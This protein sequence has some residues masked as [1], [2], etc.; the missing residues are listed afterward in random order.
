V[1]DLPFIVALASALVFP[2]GTYCADETAIPTSLSSELLARSACSACHLFP[3]PRLLDKT[4]WT[5][6][7][8]PKM[9][10]YM[11]LDKIDLAASKD[12]EALLK[13]GFLPAAPLIPESS[14][15][16]ITNWYLARAPEPTNTPSRNGFIP[17]GMQ[18]F[19]V[20]APPR[21]RTPPLTTFVQIDPKD[22]VVFAADANEQAL[23]VLGAAGEQIAAPKVGNIITSMQ[24]SKEGF[25]LGCIGHF[26]PT[27]DKLGQV[28][29]LKETGKGLERKVLFSELPRVAHIEAGDFNGDQREDFALS[30]FGFHTGRFSWFENLGE[31]KYQEHVILNKA[32]AVKSIAHDFN[33][34][35]HADLAVLYGQ[36][37]DSLFLF[38][39]DGKGE[40][41]QKDVFRRAPVY[42]H[43][44]F[45]L[46]DFNGDGEIDFLVANGDNGYYESPPKPYHGVRIYTKNGGG[47]EE[48]YFFPQHGAFKAMARD[49]D[50]DGD[51][52]IASI[53][54]FP[55][56]KE[57]PRESFVM[58][59][60]K[61]GL[62]FE[63]S[64]FRECIA[65]RWVTMDANDLDGDG[66]IDIVLA[67]LIRMPTIVPDFLK[68]LWEKQS[69]SVLYLINQTRDR[70][71]K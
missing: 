53:S 52:D 61:G 65:G 40:F 34:D 16:R 39:N 15:E 35:G 11:G 33:K 56:Y 3:D 17:L 2:P 48:A 60:N 62:K 13:A 55:D 36:E 12:G 14:W 30:M 66:D 8:F 54:F 69:P 20:V 63:P 6:H 57:S 38:I 27:E 51:L 1:R 44:Y 18:N 19:K 68:E 45:E 47:Y 24:K 23:E 31:D 9:R 70:A 71:R 4:I 43:A 42:G 58:L 22:H 49:F 5:T 32:G 50:N 67:S 28:I 26:F 21:R 29:L 41:T 25:L 10:L 7:I 64:T 37:I 46:A 59:E